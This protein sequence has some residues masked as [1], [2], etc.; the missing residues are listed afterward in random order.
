MTALIVTVLVASVMGSLHCVGMCGAFVAFAVGT[1]DNPS[2]RR[3]ALL[4]A[5]YNGGRLVTY[6]LL[7]AAGGALGAALDLGGEYVGLQRAAAVV[8]GAVMVVFGVVT[9]LRIMGARLPVAPAPKVLHRAVGAGQ[10][11][12]MGLRPVPRAL[13]IGLLTTLLPCGWLYVFAIT[14]AGTASPFWGALTMA[15]FWVGT[16]PALVALGA[17]IQS[18]T[19][20]LGRRMPAVTAIAIVAVGLYT[21]MHRMELSSAVYAQPAAEHQAVQP[22]VQADGQAVRPSE[23]AGQS[24]G[25]AGLTNDQAVRRVQQLDAG[26][27]PCCVQDGD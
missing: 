2:M 15:V 3:K 10:R 20:V 6:T 12:A 4:V 21:L 22:S 7:G 16:L 5:A 13:T 19:G 1:D 23:Q 25:Q 17:G 24:N 26:T 11:A 18:L 9:L 27:L 8:A 14:A